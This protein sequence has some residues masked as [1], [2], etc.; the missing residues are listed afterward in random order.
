[1]NRP[2][3]TSEFE[4]A[5]GGEPT[6]TPPIPDHAKDSFNNSNPYLRIIYF[7]SP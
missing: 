4:R 5:A 6:S 1:M 3:T 2:W 7:L